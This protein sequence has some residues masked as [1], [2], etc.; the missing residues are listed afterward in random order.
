VEEGCK[1]KLGLHLVHESFP[2]PKHKAQAL[3]HAVQF[4]TSGVLYFPF[5]HRSTQTLTSK[6]KSG[7]QA[8]QFVV[9]IPSQELQLILQGLQVQAIGSWYS[10]VAQE[11]KHSLFF[12]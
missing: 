3:S 11:A 1:K 12:R 8:R 9:A 2:P 4:S 5:E 6:K 7:K 10:F